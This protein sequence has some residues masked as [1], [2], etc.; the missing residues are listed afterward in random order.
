[1]G[2]V[3]FFE[4]HRSADDAFGDSAQ[5]IFGFR[6]EGG[7]YVSDGKSIVDV[8]D[9]T[10]YKIID[11]RFGDLYDRGAAGEY[12]DYLRYARDWDRDE[13]TLRVDSSPLGLGLG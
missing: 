5:G 7:C 2:I 11:H 4:G 3:E 8:V 6:G 9:E 1:M 13:A 10:T 12:G